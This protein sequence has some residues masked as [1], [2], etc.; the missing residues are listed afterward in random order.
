MKPA[1]F[2]A[3]GITLA[4]TGHRPQKLAD[5]VHGQ[6]K[7]EMRKLMKR[8]KPDFI[9]SG[10]AQGVDQWAAAIALADRIP[11]IAAVPFK[12]QAELWPAKNRETYESLLSAAHE[13]V[14]IGKSYYVGVYQDRNEWMVDSC[15]ERAAVFNGSHGGTANCV[16]Y[17]RRME[18]PITRID[19]RSW[20]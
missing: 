3:D 14:V 2:I 8:I 12:E 11:F 20:L 16:N 7:H 19:P 17:A 18:R 10:M 5:H 15:T 13:V 6:I 4:W 1:P 9:I